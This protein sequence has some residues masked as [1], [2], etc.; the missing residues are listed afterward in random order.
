M[1]NYRIIILLLLLTGC[2][3]QW[4]LKKA[5]KKNP[6]LLDSTIKYVPYQKDTIIYREIYIK[7]DSS[8][9]ESK[10]IVDSLQ[11]IYNDSFTTVYQLVDSI[12]NLKTTVVRKPRVIHDSIFV[13]IRDTVPVSVPAKYT[14]IEQAKTNWPLILGLI[15][16]ILLLLFLLL[17]TFKK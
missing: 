15:S 1:A 5:I 13:T 7:G 12:G 16:L 14:V 11:Q 3:S 2:S 6:K 17:H 9:Q 4:H 8:S 10:R